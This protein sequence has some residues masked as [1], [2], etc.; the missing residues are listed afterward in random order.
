MTDEEGEVKLFQNLLWH[1]CRISW[2]C[3]GGIR[4]WGAAQFGRSI[5]WLDNRSV[6]LS[7]DGSAN[8]ALVGDQRRRDGR[9]LVV[10][11]HEV[12]GHVLDENTLTLGTGK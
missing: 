3:F 6:R 5:D 7:V 4:V 11:R 8:A 10:R 1:H 12:L 9:G 2:L